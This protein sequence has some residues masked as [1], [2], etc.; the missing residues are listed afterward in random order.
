VQALH[1]LLDAGLPIPPVHV[2]QVNIARAEVLQRRF[3]RDVHRLD[4]VSSVVNLLSYGR[5][6]TL[7]VGG[8]LKCIRVS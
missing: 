5:I 3:N 2:Q 1:D 4:V 7:V 6:E 8:V